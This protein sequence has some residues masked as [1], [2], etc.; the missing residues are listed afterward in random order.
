[1]GPLAEPSQ[2][3]V[4]RIARALY[5]AH[6]APDDAA[7]KAAAEPN[8]RKVADRIL[9]EFDAHLVRV[10]MARTHGNKRA[11]ARLLGA[12][13]NWVSGVAKVNLAN[14]ERAIAY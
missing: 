14:Y 5:E 3:A 11:A 4:E 7:G 10:A 1:M 8:P 9:D 13:R 6:R 2:L 12:H